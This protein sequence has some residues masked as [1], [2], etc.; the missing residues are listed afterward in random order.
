MAQLF[1]LGHETV[2]DFT[3]PIWLAKIRK[4]RFEMRRH[5]TV[6]LVLGSR[7]AVRTDRAELSVGER[8]DLL[9]SIEL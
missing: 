9:D 2:L 3:S 6:S 4:V 8:Q 7:L 1:S 5:P